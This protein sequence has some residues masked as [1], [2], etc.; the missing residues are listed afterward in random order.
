MPH[1]FKVRLEPQGTLWLRTTFT[2]AGWQPG[3]QRGAREDDWRHGPGHRGPPPKGLPLGAVLAIV[4]VSVAFTSVLVAAVVH[5]VARRH[6]ARLSVGAPS[7]AYAPGPIQM[8]EL[9]PYT[10]PSSHASARAAEMMSSPLVQPI[11]A[12]VVSE[13]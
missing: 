8:T 2:E 13:P 9:Q 3:Q 10:V 7:V 12:V 6:Y 1:E 5:R 4:F 11:S